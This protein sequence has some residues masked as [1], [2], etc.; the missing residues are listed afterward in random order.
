MNLTNGLKQADFLNPQDR[1]ALLQ[2]S[3]ERRQKKESN[4]L[5]VRGAFMDVI[6]KLE[7]QIEDLKA[8]K[9]DLT[10]ADLR[11]SGGSLNPLQSIAGTRRRLRPRKEQAKKADENGRYVTPFV[12]FQDDGNQLAQMVSSLNSSRMATWGFTAESKQLG[13]TKYKLTAVLD[14]RTSRFCQMID[15][16]TFDVD[17]ADEL[18]NNALQAQDPADLAQIQPWPD[19]S[20]DAIAQYESMSDQDLIDAGLN[21]PPFHPNAVLAG[22]TFFSYGKLDEMVGADY[23]GA[24]VLIETSKGHTLTIGPNHPVLTHRGMVLA[25]SLSKGD[26]LVYDTRVDDL[27]FTSS[28]GPNSYLQQMPM[29]EDVFKS[30]LPLGKVSSIPASADQLHG[31]G[32]FCKG[33]VQVVVP[34]P[35]LGPVADSCGI[36]QLREGKL[37]IPDAGAVSLPGDGP[38]CLDSSGIHLSSTGSVCSGPSSHY[39]LLELR[40]TSM[41]P[42]VGRAFDATTET[43]VYN[44][45]GFVVSNCRTMCTV[46]EGDTQGEPAPEDASGDN[47]GPLEDTQVTTDDFAALGIDITDE[48]VAHWNEYVGL[49]PDEMLNMMFGGDTEAAAAAL[50]GKTLQVE[51]DGTI[52]FADTGELVDSTSSYSMNSVF[53]PYSGELYLTEA[54]FSAADPEAAAEFMSRVFNGMVDSGMSA[55]AQELVLDVGADAF[56]YVEMGFLPRADDWQH[57]RMDALE[58][59]QD[60]ALKDTLDALA[61]EDQLMLLNLLSNPD[62]QA[63]Q[64]LVDLNLEVDGQNVAELILSDVQGQF[65]LDLTNADQVA[66]AQE[67]FQL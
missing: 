50:E 61:E 28:C 52:S 11:N 42:Y 13:R 24:A 31:D 15:G 67:Y 45:N 7:T 54:D 18:V 36:E 25:A 14:G 21:I 20:K 46:I 33:E 53:D 3:H 4:R 32:V 1:A 6:T 59:L 27:N 55:G 30:L 37:M 26:Y 2:C 66:R 48:E 38:L 23:E 65:A 39:V 60:G 63:L 47:N 5:A 10:V 19:Q 43:G 12:S 57:I 22:T 41:V 49:A 16:R 29:V 17:T 35:G 9:D 62:E 40:S 51:D 34:Q 44:S 56:S 64:A 58:A 8:R